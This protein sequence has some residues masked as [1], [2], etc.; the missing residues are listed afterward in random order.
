[1]AATA[2][3]EQIPF[4][5]RIGG[6][7]NIMVVPGVITDALVAANAT[8]TL[9]KAAILAAVLHPDDQPKAIMVCRA[10]ASAVSLGLIPETHSCTTVAGL[11]ALTNASTT[12][13]QGYMG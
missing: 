4:S 11:V 3:L 9:L 12:F 10:L 2:V 13:K 1:M 5:K 6:E 7:L 8:V